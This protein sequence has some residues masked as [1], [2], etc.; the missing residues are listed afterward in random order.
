MSQETTL[1][2]TVMK[3]CAA[4]GPAMALMFLIGSVPLA[5]F[6]VPPYFAQHTPAEVAQMYVDNPFAQNGV[7]AFW[8]PVAVFFVWIITMSWVAPRTAND[9]QQPEVGVTMVGGEESQAAI[10]ARS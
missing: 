4:T 1:F 7:L 3:V 8:M 10:S 9:P 2:R 6:F 5:R